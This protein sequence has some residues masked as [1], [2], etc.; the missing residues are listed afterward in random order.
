M[1]FEYDYYDFGANN[2]TLTDNVNRVTF[3]ANLKDTIHTVIVGLN[4]HF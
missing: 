3:S 2:F 4:Y 1:N